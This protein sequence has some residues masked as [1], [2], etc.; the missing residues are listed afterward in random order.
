[1]GAGGSRGHHGPHAVRWP[2]RQGLLQWR[3]RRTDAD[4]KRGHLDP[5]RRGVLGH[6]LRQ[7]PL[8]GGLLQG[9]QP[10]GLD[11]QD[12]Q[13]LLTGLAR[14]TRH[15]PA[16]TEEIVT[17]F[18]IILHLRLI[19]WLFEIAPYHSYP[20]NSKFPLPFVPYTTKMLPF[21]SNTCDTQH[22]RRNISK[23]D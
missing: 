11:R 20:R 12:H 8:P 19:S 13:R 1:M 21:A 15:R 22:I 6:R 7:V 10:Q 17:E 9:G 5:D 14:G 23:I 18:A 2:G 3:L 16:A 4:W